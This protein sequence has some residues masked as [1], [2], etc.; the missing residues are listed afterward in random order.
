MNEQT[1]LTMDATDAAPLTE[2]QYVKELFSLLQESGRDT[3]GLDALL[4]HVSEMENFAKRADDK[5]ADM[6]SQ[7]AE[8]KEMQNHPVK[9]YLQ[10]AIKTLERKAAEVRDMLSELKSNIA[11]G[12]KNAVN[13]VKSQGVAALDKLASFF[14]IKSGLIGMNKN[15]DNMIRGDDKAVAKIEAFASEYHSANRHIKNMLRVA[16]GKQPLDA[17]KEAGKLAGAMAAPYKAQKAALMGFKKSIEKSVMRLEQLE[18]SA[19]AILGHRQAERSAAKKPSLLASLQ[20][21]L[22]LVEQAKREAPVRQIARIKGTE[23]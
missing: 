13:V 23:L 4:S 21:N 18:N 10:N 16:I 8:M 6:K 19:A 9:T 1:R 14:H 5:I 12:C 3:S 17:K 7:L 20:K 15:I 22:A 11:N 2:N